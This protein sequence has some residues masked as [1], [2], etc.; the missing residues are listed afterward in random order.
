MSGLL[1]GMILLVYIC[2]FHNMVILLS[3]LMEATRLCL[4]LNIPHLFSPTQ[5]NTSLFN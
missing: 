1:L 5:H 2:R 4:Q 3:G